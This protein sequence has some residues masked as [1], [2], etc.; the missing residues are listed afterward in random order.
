M[1]D[2]R[3]YLLRAADFLAN[4]HRALHQGGFGVYA[5]G[6]DYCPQ[7]HA[8]HNGA[9]VVDYGPIVSCCIAG[10]VLAANTLKLEDARFDWVL[11]ELLPTPTAGRADPLTTLAR[12][13]DEPGRTK[14]EVVAR[15]RAAAEPCT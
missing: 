12:W 5:D 6:S 9:C 1:I 3:A 13:N 8:A 7:E 11:S 2:N 4:E 15:L 10:A 14:A